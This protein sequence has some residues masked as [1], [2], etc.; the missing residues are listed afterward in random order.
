VL[1]LIVQGL[2]YSV[3]SFTISDGVFGT[4]FFFGTGFH[5]LIIVALFIF[6]F[7]IHKSIIA[8]FKSFYSSLTINNN[9]LLITFPCNNLDANKTDVLPYYLKKEFIE[10]FVG[11]TDGEGNFNIKL[12]DLTDNTFKYVQFTFQIGLHKD[13]IKILEYIKYTL[14]C[15]HISKS[16]NNKVNYFVNDKAS[17]LYILIPIF[18][19][20]NLNSSKY[21]HF[22]LFKRAVALT[23]DKNHLSNE[24]KLEIIKIKEQMQTMTGK[25]VPGSI[26]AKIN[27]TKYWLAGFIDVVGEFSTFR[28]I[29]RFKLESH[30][31]ELEL[32]NKIKEFIGVG[33]LVYT[34]PLANRKN[35]NPTI[36]LEVNKV[37]ELLD[38]LIPL[39]YKDNLVLLKSLKSIDFSLWLNIVDRYYKDYHTRPTSTVSLYSFSSPIRRMSIRHYST[40]NGS[41]SEFVGI[42]KYANAHTEK[43]KILKDNIKKAGV[44]RWTNLTNGKSYIGSGSNLSNRFRDYYSLRNLEIQIQNNKSMIYR[45]ILKY[46]YSSFSLEILEYCPVSLVISREQYYLDLFKPEYNILKIAGSSQGMKHTDDTKA[47]MRKKALTIERVELL[48]IHNSNSE[49]I[50][51]L[52]RIHSDLKIQAKRLERIRSIRAHQISVL[53]TVTNEIS[54]YPSLREAAKAIGIGKSSISQAFTRLPQGESTVWIKKKRYQITKIQH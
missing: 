12:T 40:S 25:W 20:F 36:V 45:S 5:G 4:C 33:K 41:P 54:V 1:T 35:I 21:H 29:P 43:L 2:E 10:W 27:I 32:Y 26:N 16:G 39:I 34:M 23:K 44:Y 52:K 48:K 50:E 46:G 6:F 3:S 37:K 38:V 8:Y 22:N 14:Q 18:N 28:N 31:I 17:L 47:K 7:I 51:H 13:D 15:G 53:D 49:S 9:K 24:E 42:K 30:I 11:F 19:T